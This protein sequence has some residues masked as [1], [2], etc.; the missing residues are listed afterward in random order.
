M[1][2]FTGSRREIAL[3]KETT[4]GTAEA[5]GS[6]TFIR[7]L[8]HTFKHMVEKAEQLGADGTIASVRDS[9]I[10]KEW[11]Q[12]NI[13]FSLEKHNAFLIGA[14]VCGQN[15]STSGSGTYTHVYSFDADN[16]T[17]QSF[18]VNYSDPNNG[19]QAAA[20]GMCNTLGL[21]VAPDQYVDVQ[22][23]MIADK[24]ASATYTPSYSATPAFYL[25]KQVTFK[26]ASNYAGLGAASPVSVANF[27]LTVSKNAAPYFVDGSVQ[28][29]E[30]IN[31][32]TDIRG[33]ITLL[34]EDNTFRDLGLSDTTKSI[35]FALSDGTYSLTIE[36]P[37]VDW[38]EWDQ[39]SDNDAYN[40]N[41]IV[42]VANNA[43]ATNGLVKVTVV[44]AI[45]TH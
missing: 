29:A 6:G 27:E 31:Q 42:F 34:Y 24:P 26:Y 28:P 16:N 33:S 37:T 19:D 36:L 32:R 7:H 45:A 23:D 41:T 14:L 11:G 12:G 13:P 2:I 9:K 3:T 40:S 22:L 5:P 15:P 4:R 38:R 1:A 8:G 35:S 17:H 20:L 21:K 43:D 39:E 25:P 10:V 30:I 44:D 18:T